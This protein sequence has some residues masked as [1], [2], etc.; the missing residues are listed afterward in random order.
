MQTQEGHIYGLKQASRAWFF[1]VHS[2]LPSLGFSQSK[3]DASMFYKQQGDEVTYLLIY[4]DD[5]LVTGN[6]PTL[7]QKII[8]QLNSHFSLKDLGE[9]SL[10][11]GLK[12]LE[13]LR[14]VC[15]CVSPTI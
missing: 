12:W 11:L 10:F 13:R 9:V 8:S 2:V 6:S 3:A 5:M 14:V 15:I 7:I 4:V 1:T